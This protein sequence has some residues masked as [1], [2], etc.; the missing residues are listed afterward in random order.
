MKMDL[1]AMIFVSTPD[2]I[3]AAKGP[4]TFFARTANDA[5]SRN[6]NVLTLYRTLNLIDGDAVRIQFLGVKEKADLARTSST[7]CHSTDAIHCLQHAPDLLV[8]NF[9]R[10]AKVLVADDRDGQH[11]RGV[12]IGLLNDW[13]VNVG[14]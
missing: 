10:F 13:R 9:S 4:H 8:R 2:G 1:S 14:R 6:L 11:R 7:H 5:A 3:H 12:R